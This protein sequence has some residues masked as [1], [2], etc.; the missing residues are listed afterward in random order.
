MCV[1]VPT[2]DSQN[3]H[4]SSRYLPPVLNL[5]LRPINSFRILEKKSGTQNFCVIIVGDSGTPDLTK[6]VV[7]LFQI[8]IFTVNLR[9][10]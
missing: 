8:P 2:L 4:I 10:V 3:L 1:E 9:G 6:S 5:K 7:C